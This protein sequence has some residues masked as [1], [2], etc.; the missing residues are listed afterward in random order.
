MKRIHLFAALIAMVIFAAASTSA[1]ADRGDDGLHFEGKMSGMFVGE[2]GQPPS[3]FEGRF[4]AG[5][6]LR[7]TVK[8]SLSGE[9][10]PVGPEVKV[11]PE[12]VALLHF[13]EDGR[14]QFKLR[15]GHVL[16]MIN[17]AGTPEEPTWTLCVA[18]DGSLTVNALYVVDE[19]NPGTGIFKRAHGMIEVSGPIIV[20]PQGPEGFENEIEG[21]ISLKPPKP[22]PI[23]LKFEGEFDAPNQAPIFTMAGLEGRGDLWGPE[24]K[25]GNLNGVLA[26]GGEPEEGNKFHVRPKGEIETKHFED[27]R[28]AD[29]LAGNTPKGVT[30]VRGFD[31]IVYVEMTSRS[32]HGTGELGWRASE[33]CTGGEVEE[34]LGWRLSGVLVSPHLTG[35]LKLGKPGAG[36]D[37]EAD[38]AILAFEVF[39]PGE[40]PVQ[41]PFEVNT[42]EEIINHGPD[43]PAHV[44][45]NHLLFLPKDCVGGSVITPELLAMG[46]GSVNI[47]IDGVHTTYTDPVTV[48]APPGSEHIG[49]VFGTNIGVGEVVGIAEQWIVTCSNTSQHDFHIE[50]FL[51]PVSRP[52]PDMTNNEAATN[53]NVVVFAEVNAKAAGME[54]FLNG[55]PFGFADSDADSLNDS[56]EKL[57]GTDPFNPD[58]DGDGFQDG[59]EFWDNAD[60]LTPGFD[61]VPPIH[62]DSDSLTDHQEGLIKTNPANP[63][64]DGDGPWDDHEFSQGGDPG[65]PSIGPTRDSELPFGE[66]AMLE[67][68]QQI[69]VDTDTF[70]PALGTVIVHVMDQLFVEPDGTEVFFVTPEFLAVA[71]DPFFVAWRPEDQFEI[72]PDPDGVVTAPPGYGLQVHFNVGVEPGSAVPVSLTW[73]VEASEPGHN[74]VGFFKSVWPAEEHV[75]E[76]DPANNQFQ[77]EGPLVF[78]TEPSEAD[79]GILFMN[80]NAPPEAEVGQEFVV[81][82][83]EEII[84]HG[85]DGPAHVAVGQVLFLPEDCVG[86]SVI[87]SELLALGG[88]SV[89]VSIDGVHTTYTEPL[90]VFAPPGSEHIG[91]VFGTDIGVGEVIEIAEQW[92]VTCSNTSQHDFMLDKFLNPVT[93]PDPDMANNEGQVHFSLP[94]LGVADIEVVSLFPE[95]IDGPFDPGVPFGV[96]V[97]AVFANNGPDSP[98]ETDLQINLFVPAGLVSVEITQELL[99]LSGGQVT[100]VVHQPDGSNQF[101]EIDTPTV[102][103]GAPEEN[104]GVIMNVPLESGVPVPVDILFT[105]ELLEPGDPFVSVAASIHPV[106]AEDTDPGNNQLV[107]E[108]TGGG[109]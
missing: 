93:V 56:S 84:N 65:D 50:K 12:C 13:R 69:A 19:E 99:E 82:G 26:T 32:L 18:P 24:P 75:F 49:S 109:P 80:V 39:A 64:T 78:T 79:L 44:A 74:H 70:P 100:I 88:G 106:H 85:P 43:G 66:L 7:G 92:V 55:D 71:G 33:L 9:P 37:G 21:W 83:F 62:S 25:V 87:T 105:V 57:L 59:H 103:H 60:P 97:T 11:P 30:F 38:L 46:G 5:R 81:D 16:N 4:D 86:G 95:F 58:S 17:E 98:V 89:N 23:E 27:E 20:G 6:S 77:V 14:V 10:V 2:P 29:C 101:F 36:G 90:T 73:G 61:P 51:D 63:D 22:D 72:G 47:M 1:F 34:D 8:G 40:V 68:F 102:W 35:F 104:I 54:V 94:I 45:V 107:N 52:D 67:T 31:R 48:F 96:P 76:N 91:P 53:V 28:F 15:N 3:G 108:F 41:E 42:I